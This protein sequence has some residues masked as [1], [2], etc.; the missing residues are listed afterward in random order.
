MHC[1]CW[2]NL[3]RCSYFFGEMHVEQWQELLTLPCAEV[4]PHGAPPQHF[5]F[6]FSVIT[7]ALEHYYS[8]NGTDRYSKKFCNKQENKAE[9]VPNNV[10][11]FACLEYIMEPMSLRNVWMLQHA[12]AFPRPQTSFVWLWTCLSLTLLYFCHFLT[13]LWP[14]LKTIKLLSQLQLVSSMMVP[15]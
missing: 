13:F 5:E 4:H 11:R 6:S 14:L 15:T 9:E 7:V 8:C 3:K 2:S 10:M 1:W 12:G